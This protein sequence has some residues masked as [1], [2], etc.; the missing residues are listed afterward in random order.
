MS[1]GGVLLAADKFGTAEVRCTGCGWA[2]HISIDKLGTEMPKE[3]AALHCPGCAGTSF[4]TYKRQVHPV[5][6]APETVFGFTDLPTAGPSGGR[7]NVA[8]VLNALRYL[9]P[10][11]GISVLSITHEETCPSL[12]DGK[13]LPECECTR[14]SLGFRGADLTFAGQ[15]E[16]DPTAHTRGGNGRGS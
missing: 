12:D 11:A 2:G 10:V 4:L 16:P 6:I 8:R 13:G 7:D 5:E 15:A 9:L 1:D 3:G 14:I